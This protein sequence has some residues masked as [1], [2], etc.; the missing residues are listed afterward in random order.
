MPVRRRRGVPRR[1]RAP[2]AADVRVPV[3][4]RSVVHWFPYDRVGAVNADP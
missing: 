4:A 1:D 2:A 3:Q